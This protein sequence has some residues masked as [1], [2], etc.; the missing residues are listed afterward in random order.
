LQK[1]GFRS[2]GA[3]R[4]FDSFQKATVQIRQDS[5]DVRSA[6]VDRDDG[7]EVGAERKEPRFFAPSWCTAASFGLHDRAHRDQSADDLGNGGFTEPGEL[8]DLRSRNGLFLS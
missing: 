4:A 5:P 6:Y 1:G 7:L 8:R 3:R 2:D